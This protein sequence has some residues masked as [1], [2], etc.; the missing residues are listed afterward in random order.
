MDTRASWAPIVMWS[1]PEMEHDQQRLE[2]LI[3]SFHPLCLKLWIPGTVPATLRY[4]RKDWVLLIF[5]CGHWSHILV[6][7]VTSELF[8][9]HLLEP[10]ERRSAYNLSHPSHSLCHNTATT[11]HYWASPGAQDSWQNEHRHQRQVDGRA[12]TCRAKIQWGLKTLVRLVCFW[13]YD[14]SSAYFVRFPTHTLWSGTGTLCPYRH[15]LII[16]ILSPVSIHVLP[17]TRLSRA[18][19]VLLVRYTGSPV[20]FT[21]TGLA[22]EWCKLAILA[23]LNPMPPYP[24]LQWYD[25][26]SKVSRMYMT[27]RSASHILLDP[28]HFYDNA[29]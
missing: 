11:E 18:Q 5:L 12:P 27:S 25:V 29:L 15:H 1:V 8:H 24:R 3:S 28:P 16:L 17:P 2:L 19:E 23:R 9:G 14:I 4:P 21:D 22:L 13:I 6:H 7:P 26:H 10:Q 20:R